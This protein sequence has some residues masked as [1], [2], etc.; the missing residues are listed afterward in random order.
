[1]KFSV[2]T[3]THD[4]RWLIDAYRSL[5]AQQHADWEWV[6]APNNGAADDSAISSDPR[7]KVCPVPFES[8]SIGALKQFAFTQGTGDVLV[9]LDHDDMLTPDCLA[10][11][12]KAYTANPKAGFVYSW[13]AREG[14]VTPFTPNTGWEYDWLDVGSK[15]LIAPK[16]FEASPGSLAYGYTAPDHV[17]SWRRTD[18]AALGGHDPNYSVGD[19]FDLMNRTYLRTNMVLVPKALYIYRIHGENSWLTYN[20]PLQQTIRELYGKYI[21]PLAETWAERERLFLLDLGGALSSAA[22]YL[23]IDKDNPSHITSDLERGI[24]LAD[25]SV[26]VIRAHDVLHLLSDPC[27]IMAEIWRVLA[28]GGWLLSSTPS[29]DGRGA[30]QDPLHKSYW[31]QN[32]FWYWTRPRQAKYIANKTIKFQDF[33]TDTHF[34]TP[35]H[36]EQHHW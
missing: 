34:P 35:W 8:R 32:S 20:E 15:K 6:V 18:Y 13:A 10:E 31:N 36:E 7:V 4:T 2:I 1:M 22:R 17:R 24:P 5:V 21:Y 23:V 3:P 14:M 25:N 16:V 12:E 30:F 28:D 27:F 11:L 29:T 19:D 26:G 9:E 33:R